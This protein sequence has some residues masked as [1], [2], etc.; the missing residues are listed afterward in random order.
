LADARRSRLLF[1]GYGV[2][3]KM[4][5][6]HAGLFGADSLAVLDE[7]HLVPPF[8]GYPASGRPGHGLRSLA[9]R[10]QIH[11][12]RTLDQDRERLGRHRNTLK[13]I[14]LPEQADDGLLALALE[15]LDLSEGSLLEASG[16]TFRN[17]HF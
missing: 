16:I 8:R 11:R 13:P 9:S 2:S 6:Y 3:R 1:E 10:S 15:F 4:R 5:P 7:A 12:E 17:R 14:A